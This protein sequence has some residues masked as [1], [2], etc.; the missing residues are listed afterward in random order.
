MSCDFLLSAL[1][2][3]VGG[4]AVGGVEGQALGR[5]ERE[6]VVEGRQRVGAVDVQLE[7]VIE[8]RVGDVTLTAS[9]VRVPEEGDREPVAFTAR[10]LF[11]LEEC[12]GCEV[13]MSS[14]LL[15]LGRARLARCDLVC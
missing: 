11:P 1:Q 5:C 8:P 12:V 2:L 15:L 10:Q 3:Q 14:W 7:V 6:R 9:V 4:V 13:A